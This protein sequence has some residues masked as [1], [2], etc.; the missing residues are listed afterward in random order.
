MTPPP[1]GKKKMIIILNNLLR[2][3]RNQISFLSNR[4]V[5]FI[6][7]ILAESDAYQIFNLIV[8]YESFFFSLALTYCTACTAV[9]ISYVRIS[10]KKFKID[11]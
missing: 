11:N 6:N 7:I 5:R 8:F 1:V 10:G 4:E 2:I 9:R 3:I